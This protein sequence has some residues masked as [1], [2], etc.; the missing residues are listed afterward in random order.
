MSIKKVVKGEIYFE[1]KEYIKRC[2]A[3]WE[4]KSQQ[5]KAMSTAGQD[6]FEPE[7]GSGNRRHNMGGGKEKVADTPKAGRRK[8]LET[9]KVGVQRCTGRTRKLTLQL[10]ADRL[11]DYR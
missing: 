7:I 3:T 2:D 6:G 4:I 10:L 1:K 9:K 8:K 5:H 11:M